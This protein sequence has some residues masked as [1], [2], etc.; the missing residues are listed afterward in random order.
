MASAR[1]QPQSARDLLQG[2]PVHLGVGQGPGHQHL[3]G[4]GHGD[5]VQH[6][7]AG[8][9]GVGV[10]GEGDAGALLAVD[11]QELGAAPAVGLPGHLLVGEHQE[12]PGPGGALEGLAHRAGHP[13]VLVPDVHAQAAAPCGRGPGQGHHLGGVGAARWWGRTGRSSGPRRRRPWPPPRPRPWPGPPRAPPAG[14]S[15]PGGAPAGCRGPPGPPRSPAGARPG[16]PARTGRSCRTGTAPG[17]P[18]G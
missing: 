11:L 9:V 8:G 4:V 15:R 1:E 2:A 5:R 10:D 16:G 18:A 6:A 17:R 12:G 7:G 14:R 13:V 3:P